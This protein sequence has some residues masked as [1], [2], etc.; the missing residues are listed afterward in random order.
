MANSAFGSTLC[1]CRQASGG[2]S[3]YSAWTIST[4][5]GQDTGLCLL[6]HIIS[7]L[8]F[9]EVCK[10]YPTQ[11]Y[12][13]KTVKE[14]GDRLD[15]IPMP[16]PHVVFLCSLGMRQV[17]PH[18]SYV[19]GFICVIG[20]HSQQDIENETIQ[21]MS[22]LHEPWDLRCPSSHHYTS[23]DQ[24]PYRYCWTFLRKVRW[25]F[26]RDFLHCRRN[27]TRPSSPKTLVRPAHFLYHYLLLFTLSGLRLIPRSSPFLFCP[28]NKMGRPGMRHW[29]T[30]V[31]FLL[32]GSLIPR[33]ILFA[34]WNNSI[35]WTLPN[36]GMQGSLGM[37]LHESC[38]FISQIS[39]LQTAV[40]R[41]GLGAMRM[42][43]ECV[44]CTSV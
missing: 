30:S 32:N 44:Y 33:P 13:G 41:V 38:S 25:S 4:A 28:K 6:F 9:T 27:T 21:K 35:T 1:V 23:P 5:Q 40:G 10:S 16:R 34:I 17:I 18:V 43:L 31:W 39:V 24:S 7:L 11:V 12:T 42:D 26:T 19:A 2:I 29:L 20:P 36:S 22:S 3:A 8:C 15:H 14:L 37:R